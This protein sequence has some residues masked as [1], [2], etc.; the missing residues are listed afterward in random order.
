MGFGDKRIDRDLDWESTTRADEM[1]G[2]ELP[3]IYD[4]DKTRGSWNQDRKSKADA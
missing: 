3:M 2:N 4:I 1:V